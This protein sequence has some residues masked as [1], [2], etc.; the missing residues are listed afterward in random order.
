MQKVWP[1]YK[2]L[3]FNPIANMVSTSQIAL[4]RSVL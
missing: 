4:D 3:D 2:K 1:E